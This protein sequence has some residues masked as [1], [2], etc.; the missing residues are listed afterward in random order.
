MT[1]EAVWESEASAVSN[2]NKWEKKQKAV[3]ERP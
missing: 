2:Q 1:T 3:Q